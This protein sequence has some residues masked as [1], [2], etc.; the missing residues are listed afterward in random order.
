MEHTASALARSSVMASG[1]LLASPELAGIYSKLLEAE[2]APELAREIV[3]ALGETP[4]AIDDRLPSPAI[5]RELE[6]RFTADSEVGSPSGR[7]IVT[8][9]GPPGAGKTTTL[10]KLAVACGL[11]RR[12][13]VHI[14][15][16]DNYRIAAGEQLRAYAGILGV[17][18]QSLDTLAGLATALTEHRHKDLILIDTPGHS[19]KD[20]DVA[21]DLA[22]FLSTNAEIDTHLILSA[23]VKS[24]DL[25]RAVDRFQMFRPRKLLFT[26][27]DETEVYGPILNESARTGLPVSFLCDGQQIPEDLQPATVQRLARLIAPE[28]SRA[29][30]ICD[31]AAA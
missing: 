25:K 9:V 28:E 3:A 6:R 12:L 1:V 2:V 8:L 5:I 11:Q 22:N 17:G 29:V 27:L 20:I 30:P 23:A 4:R 31:L 7:R 21:G 19:A 15:S 16:M 18:F 24:V 14:I 26:R 13:S 10:V